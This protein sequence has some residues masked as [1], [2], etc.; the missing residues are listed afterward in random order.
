[1]LVY[2][3]VSSDKGEH[4]LI[5]MKFMLPNRPVYQVC[6]VFHTISLNIW[7]LKSWNKYLISWLPF[8]VDFK[9]NLIT[10]ESLSIFFGQQIGGGGGGVPPPP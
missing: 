8:H 7:L 1:M 2:V 6:T 10:L 5:G 3:N 4:L 9:S